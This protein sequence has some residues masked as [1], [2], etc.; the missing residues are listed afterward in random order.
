MKNEQTGN[1]FLKGPG[2]CSP[3]QPGILI[4]RFSEQEFT[5]FYPPES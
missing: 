2:L 4:E 1:F 5:Q 3:S